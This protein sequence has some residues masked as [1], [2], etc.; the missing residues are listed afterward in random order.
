M[1]APALELGDIFRLHGPSYL[2]TFG[3]SLSHEQKQALGRLRPAAQRPE[4]VMLRSAICAATAK[5]L[6][7]RA[8]IAIARSVRDRPERDGLNSVPPSYCRSRTP[9][10]SS[11]RPNCS[12]RWQCATSGVYGI[13][14]HAAAETLLQ[15]AADPRHL[16]ARIGFLAVLHTWGQTF[17]II[18]TST[19]SFPAAGS[20]PTSVTGFRAAA[21]FS[22]RSRCSAVCSAP[23]SSLI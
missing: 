15:I 5:F 19:A 9:I 20:R 7:A 13:L 12:R 4:V 22:F 3:D 8:A 18:R 6:I 14:F 17:I 11:P 10:S 23:N 16:G 21:S 2:T 1:R